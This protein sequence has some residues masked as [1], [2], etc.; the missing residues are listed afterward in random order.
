MQNIV[1]NK[2]NRSK[3]GQRIIES[4]FNFLRSST[5]ATPGAKLR[6]YLLPLTRI[7]LKQTKWDSLL[8][9]K[10]HRQGQAKFSE[11]KLRNKK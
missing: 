2:R 7:H 4:E 10:Q 11:R 5:Q 1:N 8:E 9:G 3:I 6:H